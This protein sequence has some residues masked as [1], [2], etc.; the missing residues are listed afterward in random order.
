MSRGLPSLVQGN[1]EKCRSAAIA[2]VDAYNRPGC[3]F[4]TAQYV[5]LMVIAW[6]AAG[7]TRPITPK[8]VALAKV[9]A[10][11]QTAA[12]TT[13]GARNK[14]QPKGGE[15]SGTRENANQVSR[16]RA[17][18]RNTC[19]ARRTCSRRTVAAGCDPTVSFAILG[20][21]IAGYVDWKTVEGAAL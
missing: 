20:G 13:S 6:R 14:K 4:R 15:R 9:A 1:I 12:I 3:R 16:V 19:A 10:K 7:S 18:A 17:T 5:V 21:S 11:P 2:A 8:K